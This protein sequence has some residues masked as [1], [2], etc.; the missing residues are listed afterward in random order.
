MYK[1][2]KT[3]LKPLMGYIY[4]Q[5]V[6]SSITHSKG[7]ILLPTLL[8][9]KFIVIAISN[10]ID[11]EKVPV[12]IGDIV[13]PYHEVMED[14]RKGGVIDHIPP[15]IEVYDD[16]FEESYDCIHFTALRGIDGESE[17]GVTWEFDNSEVVK[18]GII[19]EKAY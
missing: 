16:E 11:T 13:M 14:M 10:D 15:F 4:T 17:Q 19:T 5:R 3:K 8:T 2:R 12:K 6:Q 9:E 18:S 1:I 7:G